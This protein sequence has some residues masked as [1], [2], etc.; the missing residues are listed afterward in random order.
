M[1]YFS[2]ASTRRADEPSK[3]KSQKLIIQIV[4]RNI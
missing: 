2:N 4:I 1:I 3:K